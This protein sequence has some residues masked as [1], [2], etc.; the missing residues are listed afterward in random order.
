[1]F[2]TN[3]FQENLEGLDQIIP[4]SDFAPFFFPMFDGFNGEMSL[5][6]FPPIPGF[7]SFEGEDPS[8]M[9]Q[10]FSQAFQGFPEEFKQMMQFTMDPA[11][12]NLCDP[13]DALPASPKPKSG[14]NPECRRIGSITMEE[15]RIKVE[16]FLEKRKHR[17][18]KKKISYMC[19]KKVA[20]KRVRV[21]GRFVSRLQAEEILG[22]KVN[23][24]SD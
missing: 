23:L 24:S 16:K 19:R 3:Y 13:G 22:E 17:S 8:Q 11:M 15:R 9:M 6:D 4:P 20:D 18:F 1:M 21:K 7:M 2:G 12:Q 5:K 14:V 10:F